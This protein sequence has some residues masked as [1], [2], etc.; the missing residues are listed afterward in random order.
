MERG[1]AFSVQRGL[2]AA[3]QGLGEMSV[4]AVA[5]LAAGRQNLVGLSVVVGAA[6]ERPA[7]LEHREIGERAAPL[8]V[9]NL[10]E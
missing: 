1:E 3:C 5:S 9:A 7:K 10:V 2:V 4:L 6:G 8:V